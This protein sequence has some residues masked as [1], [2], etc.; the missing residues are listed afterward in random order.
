M[1]RRENGLV[2]GWEGWLTSTALVGQ[3]DKR[4]LKRVERGEGSR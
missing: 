1:G 2:E 3:S 4:E